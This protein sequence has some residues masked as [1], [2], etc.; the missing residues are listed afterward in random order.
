MIR[1]FFFVRNYSFCAIY[2]L[3]S[4][5]CHCLDHLWIW[6]GCTYGV[7]LVHFSSCSRRRI[8]NP[9]TFIFI[10]QFIDAPYILQLDDV[11][12]VFLKVWVLAYGFSYIAIYFFEM[13]E[14]YHTICFF[15]SYHWCV[16]VDAILSFLCKKLNSGDLVK[17]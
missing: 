12:F 7:L 1:I 8:S 17:G 15:F 14:L 9:G 3:F 11:F 2:I 6:H 16:A 5:Y 4:C 10:F 13:H